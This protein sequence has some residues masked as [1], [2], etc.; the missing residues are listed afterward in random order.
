[1]FNGG[2]NGVRAADGAGFV[3]ARDVEIQ[4]S[5]PQP[6]ITSWKY[7][8][9]AYVPYPD[10]AIAGGETI[11]IYGSGFQNGANV[12]IGSTTVASTRLDPNRITFTAPSLSA[13]AYTLFVT[14]PSGGTAVYV[15]GVIYNSY[16]VWNVTS[17]A[18]TFYA[19]TSSVAFNLNATGSPNLTFSLQSGSSLPTGL[20]LAANG[21]ISGTTTVANTTVYNFTVIATD[22]YAQSI[23]SSITYTITVVLSET[24][25]DY[26]TLLLNGETNTNT[27]IQ[28]TSTNNFA[29]TPIGAATSNRFSPV[30]GDGYYGNSFDGSSGFLTTAANSILAP[31]GDFTAEAWAYT[32]IN[33]NYQGIL[34]TRDSGST[35]GWG[36]TINSSGNLEFVCT[37]AT[38]YTGTAAPLNKWFHVAMSKVGST[39]YCYLNGVQVGTLTSSPA[40]SYNSLGLTIGRYY[41]NGTNQYW[42]N[43][44]VSNARYINGTGVYTGSSFTVPTTP[45]TAITNTAVLTCQSNR[46]IDNSTNALAITPSG[47]VKVVPNQPFGAL[48]S[49][50]QNYG[51]A[52]FDGSTGYINSTSNSTVVGTGDF[53]IEFWAYINAAASNAA[54]FVDMRASTSATAPLIYMY[55]SNVLYYA[56]GS[57]NQIT[58]PTLVFNQWYHIAV[59][60]ASGSTKMF[61]NGVQVGSTYSDSNSYVAQA[62]RP[63]L[64]SFG[65]T[66]GNRFN[67]YLSNLRVVNQALYTTTFTPP[68]APLTAVANTSLLTVQNKNSAN[69]NVFYD[70][71]TNNSAITRN[72]L[73]T[74]GTFSPFSQTGWSTFLGYGAYGYLTVPT[75]SNYDITGANF[76]VECWVNYTSWNT[77]SSSGMV[78]FNNF[79]GGN[80]WNLGFGSGAGS[81]LVFSTYS[82]GSGSQTI[83]STGIVTGTNVLLGNWYHLA[84]MQ[85]GSTIYFFLN[86]VMTYSTTAPNGV[87]S[88]STM[89]IGVYGQNLTYA[90]NPYFYI[91]NA[92][93]VKGYAIYPTSGFTPSTTP[94]TAVTGTTFLAFQNNRQLDN[95]SIGATIT[96]VSSGTYPLIQAFSPFGPGVSYSS[97]NNG[98]SMYF[99]GSTGY[100]T[101]PT[102][103]LG[104]G[105]FTIECWLYSL[106]WGTGSG[107]CFLDYRPSGTSGVYPTLSFTTSGQI[108]FYTNSTTV[109]SGGT[110]PLNTWLHVALVKNGSSTILYVN[111]V[112]TGSTYSDTNTYLAGTGT[113]LIGGS[114]Y[115]RPAQSWNGY[116][117]NV[118][119]VPGVALYTS[120]FT[121]PTAPP[122]PSQNTSVLLLGTNTGIQ[123]ATGKN[124]IIG[125]GSV[126]TQANTVKYGSGAMYF[127]GSTG[128]LSITNPWLTTNFGSGNWTIECYAYLNSFTATQTQLFAL[129][130]NT[131]NQYTG[132][133]IYVL[134]SGKLAM[135]LTNT[136]ASGWTVNDT[137]GQG[138]ALSLSTW[139]HLAFVKNGTSITMYLNGVAQ[140][141]PY[142]FNQAVYFT[143]STYNTI[144]SYNL[145]SYMLNGYMDEIRITNGVARYTANFTPPSVQFLAQ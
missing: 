73:V 107:N 113:P 28:D 121:P 98:G 93:I 137:S 71:S 111:G 142:T 108:T 100:L 94:L 56:V 22:S 35:T 70:D 63:I 104:S 29:L 99:D 23:Q 11:V 54:V 124:N 17:Y 14:N 48:P 5:N 101:T 1:M 15:P 64:G 127:D 62:S 49:G 87:G 117:S 86:G 135:S 85:S 102:T 119:I 51:S 12:V 58:G 89:A 36:I 19:T 13:G 118:R 45:L 65:D 88:G 18:N 60:R 138:S 95:S 67:G 136:G 133:G 42:L 31:S 141:T 120:T 74:Q 26:T 9:G 145:T 125:Y 131:S 92:R 20:T 38:A 144:G 79:T 96:P 41:T 134:P 55:T 103:A 77:M 10:T 122:T 132:I 46:F 68:T 25:F 33:N 114:S 24:Y 105:S 97:A 76:T 91:S 81:A 52:L 126:K 116:I 66:V 47:T 27:Y 123:D 72:G 39:V 44:Y 2:F 53:T 112:Q 69:N 130:Q 75:N 4:Q 90:G 139:Y 80:G 83:T 115:S 143:T 37:G 34:S 57:T 84:V 3:S 109:I 16:P 110:Y 140:G 59:S 21:Y 7:T 128:Y 82:G 129:Q 43:G 61:V 6:Q 40:I 50:V 8:N 78:I 32:T 30:W 106:S